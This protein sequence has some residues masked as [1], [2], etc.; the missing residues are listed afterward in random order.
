LFSQEVVIMIGVLLFCIGGLVGAVISRSVLPPQGR[1]DLEE[2][3]RASRQ[4]LEHY[5]QSVTQHFL[6]TS[7][8]INNL[9]QSYREV[10]EHL[11]QG[12]MEL[13]DAETGRKMLEAGES[14]HVAH[15]DTVPD[16]A[17]EPPRDWAPKTPGQT[18]TLS[19]E[20]GLHDLHEEHG[21]EAVTSPGQSR[22]R[23]SDSLS[24]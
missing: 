15:E 16:V 5:R 19:E 7:Q 13:A 12:A 4:E 24:E 22:H 18:G 17:F 14:Q 20:F 6:E 1:R 3:L 11:A 23:K 10:H 2:Q 21:V 9:T 8:R